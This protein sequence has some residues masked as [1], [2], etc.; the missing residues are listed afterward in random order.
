MRSRSPY[1]LWSG[2]IAN[3]PSK[4]VQSKVPTDKMSAESKMQLATKS[5][6]QISQGMQQATK[7]VD[8]I[9]QGSMT[10]LATKSASQ[11]SQGLVGPQPTTKIDLAF[12][13]K[14][15][16]EAAVDS[17]SDTQTENFPQNPS[18]KGDGGRLDE[19]V[20]THFHIRLLDTMSFL[21]FINLH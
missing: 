9:S 3:E 12:D 2:S 16:K 11:I 17:A 4:C 1:Y 14:A 18:L 6:D 20:C 7:S 19:V 5:A 8:Q 15:L 13:Y 21:P 10:Q